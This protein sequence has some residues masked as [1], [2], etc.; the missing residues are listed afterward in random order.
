M[1]KKNPYGKH[2]E[3]EQSYFYCS[4]NSNEV[5]KKEK[6]LRVTSPFKSNPNEID[7]TYLEKLQMSKYRGGVSAQHSAGPYYGQEED[8]GSSY[9]SQSSDRDTSPPPKHLEKDFYTYI[10]NHCYTGRNKKS[11]VSVHELKGSGMISNLNIDEKTQEQKEIEKV[12]KTML[13][14][15]SLKRML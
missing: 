11:Q 10:L 14:N 8:G 6:M 5:S 1:Q 13:D 15:L 3:V 4:V 7:Q 2:K 9:S 12:F